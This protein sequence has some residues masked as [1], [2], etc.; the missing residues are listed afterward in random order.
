MTSYLNMS[1]GSLTLYCSLRGAQPPSQQQELTCV[2]V[3]LHE[4][5]SYTRTHQLSQH[6][7]DTDDVLIPIFQKQKLGIGE[8]KKLFQSCMASK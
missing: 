7:S 6:P 3:S 1:R 8:I 5:H 2:R 4:R